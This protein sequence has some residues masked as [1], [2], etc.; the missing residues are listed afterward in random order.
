M[1]NKYLCKYIE[2]IHC[3]IPRGMIKKERKLIILSNI[4]WRRV[5][6]TNQQKI[7][8]VLCMLEDLGGKAYLDLLIQHIDYKEIN[9]TIKVLL[10]KNIINIEYEFDSRINI[11]TET[12]V[13]LIVDDND[14]DE[15]INSLKNARKQRLCL[16]ILKQYGKCSVKKLLNIA[17]TGRGTL[18]SLQEKGYIK[19]VDIE[20][21]RNPLA[22]KDFEIFP[23]LIPNKEQQ[24]AISKIGNCIEKNINSSFLI[25]GITGSGKTE[26]YLQLIEKVIKKGKQGIMLVPEISLT[27][28]IVARFMGRFGERIAVFHSGLSDGERYDEWR[29]IASNEVDIV[30]GARSAIFAPLK[31]LGIII[32]DEE[33]EHT[34]KSEQS[35]RYHAIEVADYRR[36]LEGAVLVLGSATP[37]IESYYKALNGQL[38]LINLT[39]RAINT[40][41]PKVEIVNMT[42]QLEIGNRGIL[43]Y[44][45]INAID[46]NLKKKNKPFCF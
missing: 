34:Y 28:Q 39:K 37:S 45:L 6:K 29:R 14:W 12:Y 3:L 19:F 13:H 24:I 10:E 23:K 2:A 26:V 17:D 21:K 43:S 32:I 25:H 40:G 16:E 20:V 41:L 9:D 5:I 33:H 11:K 31:N 46:K 30:I 38:K 35:P 4:N 18:N 15:A 8:K 42:R 44:E 7:Q 36:Q 27:P 1:K 22:G